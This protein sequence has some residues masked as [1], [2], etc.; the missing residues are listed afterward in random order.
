MQS[1]YIIKTHIFMS[2]QLIPL[3]RCN[4]IYHHKED[5][6]TVH[7]CIQSTVL[8]DFQSHS[9]DSVQF[10]EEPTCLILIVMKSSSMLMERLLVSKLVIM[11]L[12]PHLLYVILVIATMIESSQLERLFVLSVLWIIHFQT[13]VMYLQFKLSCQLNS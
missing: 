8:V 11:L 7:S 10:M 9:Q 2:Q 4:C 5:M 6:V 1:L 12:K 3:R 13:Q